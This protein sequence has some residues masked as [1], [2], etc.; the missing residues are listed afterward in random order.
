MSFQRSGIAPPTV[1]TSTFPTANPPAPMQGLRVYA[2]ADFGVSNG[3]NLGDPVAHAD[4]VMLDDIYQLSPNARSRRLALSAAGG[5]SALKVDAGGQIG[6]PGAAVHLDCCLTFMAPDG[7]LVEAL[8]LIELE[9]NSDLIA[10]TWL[11]P[12]ADLHPKTDY[13]LIA[14]DEGIARARFAALACV[15]F[16]RGTRI[17]LAS[18]AQC[19]IEDIRPGDRI[20]TR[21]NG[22]QQVRWTGSQ[23]VRATGAFAP[24]RIRKGALNNS[25][26][27]RLSPNQRLFVYQ[28]SDRLRTGRAE[29]MI[30][31][32]HLVNGDTVTRSDGGFVDYHQILFDDHEFIY[33]EGIATESL[34][35]DGATCPALPDEVQERVSTARR[36]RNRPRPVELPE[37]MLDASRAVDLLRQ[38]SA[39]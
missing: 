27:L 24:I 28:R 21:D 38:A 19:P 11:L 12:L 34:T 16:T 15:S 2:A 6:A 18:G 39:R 37:G 31:A 23:T 14:L 33:A 13:A 36:P 22:I 17:T 29:V 30:K 25:E 7:S 8:V 4:E 9:P 5:L 10:A 20:L 35:L 3:A 32:E 26:D 1:S